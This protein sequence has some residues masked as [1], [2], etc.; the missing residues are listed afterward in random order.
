MTV[1]SEFSCSRAGE[2]GLEFDREAWDDELFVLG[3]SVGYNEITS[4][5]K[6]KISALEK[7]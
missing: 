6:F 5:S 7:Y 2:S 1:F 4:D 3:F